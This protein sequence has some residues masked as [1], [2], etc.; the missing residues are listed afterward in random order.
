MNNPTLDQQKNQQLE[1][2]IARIETRLQGKFITE[3]Q[4]KLLYDR[5]TLLEKKVRILEHPIKFTTASEEKI[6]KLFADGAK[7]TRAEVI[8][9]TGLCNPTVDR[10]L[11][12]LKRKGLLMCER[13]NNGANGGHYAVYE[14]N[15]RYHPWNQ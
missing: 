10:W 4:W 14:L 2:L 9:L 3:E 8:A 13:I 1:K 12:V 11:N 6:Y 5:I 15:D 7:L